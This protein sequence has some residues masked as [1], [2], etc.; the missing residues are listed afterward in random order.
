MKNKGQRMNIWTKLLV[1][2]ILISLSSC[3][4][5]FRTEE[6]NEEVKVQ[7]Y[8]CR[9]V[10]EAESKDTIITISRTFYN[11]GD[12]VLLGNETEQFSSRILECNPFVN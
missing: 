6:V 2:C 1:L 12:L 5:A 7:K 9:S 11:P 10:N 4:G 3:D 8:S